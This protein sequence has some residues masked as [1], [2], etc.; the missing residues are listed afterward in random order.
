[1]GGFGGAA[2]SDIEFLRSC[3]VMSSRQLLREVMPIR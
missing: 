2:L 3:Q 1:V